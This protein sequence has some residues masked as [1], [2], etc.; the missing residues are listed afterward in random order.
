[1]EFAAGRL[2]DEHLQRPQRYSNPVCG[3]I[4]VGQSAGRRADFLLENLLRALPW[5]GIL[6]DTRPVIVHRVA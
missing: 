3:P 5:S 1:M 6:L 2:L 4:V